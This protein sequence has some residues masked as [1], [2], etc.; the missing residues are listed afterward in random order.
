MLMHEHSLNVKSVEPCGRYLQV[1]EPSNL[2]IYSKVKLS[3]SLHTF[4]PQMILQGV[5]RSVEKDPC[6]YLLTLSL[7]YVNYLIILIS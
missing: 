5:V 2:Y 7:N 4:T 1:T 6:S 3:V